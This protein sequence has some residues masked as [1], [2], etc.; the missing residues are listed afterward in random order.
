VSYVIFNALPCAH[1]LTNQSQPNKLQPNQGENGQHYPQHRLDI[2]CH[3]KETFVRSILLPS[4]W[5]C[6]FEDP[7]SIPRGTVDFVPPAQAN[8]ASTGDVFEVVEVNGEQEDRDD[9]DEDEV[10]REELQAK[11]VYEKRCCK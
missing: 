4:L 10:A 5:V 6:R 7:A 11:K 3:P 9:E 1:E 8:E 2:K